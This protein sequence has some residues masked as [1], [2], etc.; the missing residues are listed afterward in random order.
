MAESAGSINTQRRINIPE[1]NTLRFVFMVMIF[2]HHMNNCT[3]FPPG[4]YLAVSFFFVL[5]G[6]SMTIGYH[7]RIQ[8]PGFSY[9]KYIARRATK[10]Y[11][12]HWLVLFITIALEFHWGTHDSNLFWPRLTTNFFLVQSFIPDRFFYFSFNSPSWYL[13]NTLF[14][15]LLFPFILKVLCRSKKSV[16]TTILLGMIAIFVLLV[17]LVP[18]EYHHAILY[19]NPLVRLL[20]FVLGIYTGL[21]FLDYINRKP[22]SMIS[23]TQL[24]IVAV[25]CFCVVAFVS[26][27]HIDKTINS[28][29]VNFY[30]LIFCPMILSISIISMGRMD[31]SKKQ[32]G[33]GK[34]SIS[35][36][37]Q[38]GGMYSFTFYMI[39][40]KCIGIISPLCG[41][42]GLGLWITVLVTFIG[43]IIAAVI[44][45]RYFVEPI[46]K[47]LMNKINNQ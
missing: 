1:L 4:G 43:T 7:D 22:S 31:S 12:I 44:C 2:F 38:L 5:S 27:A 32:L 9:Y 10:F 29:I 6:F 45:Q 14:Y 13:C 3:M 15:C 19:V 18:K 39:H 24:S 20:D 33:G 8:S 41:K 11:P 26:F 34:F 17:V 25:L 16:R 28:Y 30:W 46:G 23:S 40:L 37:L 36:L 42:L 47:F 21:Y 35:K